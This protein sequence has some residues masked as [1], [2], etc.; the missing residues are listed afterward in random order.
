M[1]KGVVVGFEYDPAKSAKNLAKH[2]VDFEQAQALWDDP[3][4]IE[5]RLAYPDEPRWAV[6]GMMG[7]RHWT[8]IVTRRGDNTRIISVRRSH[9]KEERAYEDHK[10]R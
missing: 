1:V 3:D 6:V 10:E 4:L 5:V 7:G 9:P 2:G 8:G